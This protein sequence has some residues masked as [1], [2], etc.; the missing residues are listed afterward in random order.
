M[1]WHFVIGILSQDPQSGKLRIFDGIPY[2][3]LNSCKNHSGISEIIPH[4]LSIVICEFEDCVCS[5]MREAQVE[6]CWL[7]NTTT[8]SNSSPNDDHTHPTCLQTSR[9]CLSL[10]FFVP[11]TKGLLLYKSPRC[12]GACLKAGFQTSASRAYP[13]R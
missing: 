13:A 10:Y 12:V 5:Q 2:N 8:S 3:L 11:Q 4:G 7:H 6:S 1:Q 9:L